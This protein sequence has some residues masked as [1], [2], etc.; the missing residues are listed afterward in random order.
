MSAW[1]GPTPKQHA[2]GNVS[3]MDGISK[4]GNPHLTATIY[5]RARAVIR[6]CEDKYDALSVWL[7]KLL[8]TT[9]TCNVIV[10]LANKLARIAWAVMAK[11]QKYNANALIVA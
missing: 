6:W 2:S 10:A 4:R 8:N 11:G 9:P 5:S 1:V 3:R 7:Q